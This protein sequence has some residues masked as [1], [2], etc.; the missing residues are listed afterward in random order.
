MLVVCS[1]LA[2]RTKGIFV[3]SMPEQVVNGSEFII[4]RKP[5]LR[6]N[7]SQRMICGHLP[8]LEEVEMLVVLGISHHSFGVSVGLSLVLPWLKLN[9]HLV[10]GVIPLLVYVLLQGVVTT[11]HS[12]VGRIMLH[13]VV[14]VRNLLG[15]LMGHNLLCLNWGSTV[16]FVEIVRTFGYR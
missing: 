5:C 14:L 3:G 16:F 4:V 12:G 15:P 11:F 1:F 10:R 8:T 7:G 6:V 2:L 13:F 9:A